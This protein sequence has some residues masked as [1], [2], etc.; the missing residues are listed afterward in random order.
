MA[1]L[2]LACV[3]VSPHGHKQ[4]KVWGQYRTKAPSSR[5]RTLQQ[6]K[7][8]CKLE[9]S[10]RLRSTSPFVRVVKARLIQENNRRAWKLPRASV[11]NDADTSKC[12][13][14][15]VVLPGFLQGSKPYRDMQQNLET[16]GYPTT[17]MPLNSLEWFPTLWGGSFDFYL[18]KLQAV[19]SE[20]YDKHGGQK[21]HLVAHSAG[22]WIARLFLGAAVYNGRS[23]NGEPMVQSLLCLGSPHYSLEEYPF[24]RVP[25][26]RRGE[27]DSL[28]DDAARGSSLR[29]ANRVYPGAHHSSVRYISACG[30]GVLGAP[31]QPGY[32]G[33]AEGVVSYFSY[34]SN[35]GEGAVWGDAVTDLESAK[36]QG[37]TWVELE[38]VWHSPSAK[39]KGHK[40]YGD[41]EV[42]AQLVP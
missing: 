25:E 41:I 38:G 9:T 32:K 42:L 24:G 1:C 19:V 20:V 31:W 26:R 39:G 37:A 4:N 14:P 10:R 11:T 12:R 29:F 30:K 16:L 15:I 34:R 13:A 28:L 35:C 3:T 27:D 8:Q 6:Q 33:A 17:V 22:G 21:V 23:Y 5:C 40:W 36:L 18:E 2:S 7:H